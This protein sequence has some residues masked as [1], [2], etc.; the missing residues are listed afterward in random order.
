MLKFSFLLKKMSIRSAIKE[1]QKR[2]KGIFTLIIREKLTTTYGSRRRRLINKQVHK[3]QH[4]KLGVI[5]C[6]PVE[7]AIHAHLEFHNYV[8]FLVTINFC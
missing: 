7:N 5:S 8:I 2:S 6:V 1:R 4:R 3:I